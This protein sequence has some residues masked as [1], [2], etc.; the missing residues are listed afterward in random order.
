MGGVE[1]GFWGFWL[2]FL[3]LGFGRQRCRAKERPPDWSLRLD[4]LLDGSSVCVDSRPCI[5][6][7]E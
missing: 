1:R 4:V 5:G 3:G 6:V 2:G 7:R